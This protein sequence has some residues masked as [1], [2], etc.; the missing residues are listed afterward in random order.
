[1]R[2]PAFEHMRTAKVQIRLRGCAVWS[3]PLLSA[4]RIIGY[5]RMYEW[6][7]KAQMILYACAGWS[8]HFAHVRRHFFAWRGQN[9]RDESG[10]MYV[11]TCSFSEDSDQLMH[12]CS[13]VRIFYWALCWYPKC[14]RTGS[15]DWSGWVNAQTKLCLCNKV[16]FRLPTSRILAELFFVCWRYTTLNYQRLNFPLR[17]SYERIELAN[18]CVRE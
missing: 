17:F 11:M 14:L 9:I 4:Y 8:E 16:H 10:K 3:G 12:P 5:Y 7:A 15:E 18:L 1:M 2:K 13:L 6:W